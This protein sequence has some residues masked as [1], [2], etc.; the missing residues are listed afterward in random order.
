MYS[1]LRCDHPCGA[2]RFN[3]AF[4]GVTTGLWPL[5]MV[6]GGG[7]L[8]NIAPEEG[9]WYFVVG[10]YNASSNKAYTFYNNDIGGGVEG[11]DSVFIGAPMGGSVTDVLMADVQVYKSALNSTQIKNLYAQGKRL[12][13]RTDVFIQVQFN[14]GS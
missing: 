1:I 11:S 13:H 10:V 7:Q 8:N 12:L 3:G 2:L 5:Q 6:H 14:G 4:N 9:E